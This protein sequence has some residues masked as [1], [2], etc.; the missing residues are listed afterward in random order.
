MGEKSNDLNKMTIKA[1]AVID[2]NV[3]V[4]YL[5]GTLE[6][7]AASK[8]GELIDSKTIIPLYDDRIL[9]EYYEVLNYKKFGFLP[10]V[11]EKQM[12]K[13]L[14]NGIFVSDV[15]QLDLCFKDETDIPFFEVM[16]DTQELGTSLVTGNI[17]HYPEGSCVTPQQ[18][19]SNLTYMENFVVPLK[20]IDYEN[21]VE[22]KILQLTSTGKYYLGNLLP[23]KFLKELKKQR[24]K[25]RE[26]ISINDY[27]K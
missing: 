13:I 19:L 4:S 7:S 8:V 27:I 17:K 22:E 3:I 10:E 23:E 16:M 20:Q 21:I 18:L 26:H 25:P 11:I 1:F 5:Y 12:T 15:K 9:S 6:S 2:T 14:A 24:L